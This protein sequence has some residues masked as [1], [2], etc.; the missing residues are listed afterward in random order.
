MSFKFLPILNINKCKK[1]NNKIK[2]ILFYMTNSGFS[3]AEKHLLFLAIGLIKRG[4][5]ITLC[6]L[7]LISRIPQIKVRLHL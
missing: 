2:K 5:N 1:T 6:N 7:D 4:Y 3:G